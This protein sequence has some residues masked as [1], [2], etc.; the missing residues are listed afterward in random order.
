[1]NWHKILYQHSWLPEKNPKAY[2]DCLT[3]SLAPPQGS[4]LLSE[5]SQQIS[6]ELQLN[7]AL[8]F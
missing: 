2:C 5:I 4:H 3:F 6:N 1:M 8:A 7:L